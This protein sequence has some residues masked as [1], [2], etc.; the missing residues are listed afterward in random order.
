MFSQWLWDFVFL[1]KK[2]DDYNKN[3]DLTFLLHVDILNVDI[4]LH[5][6]ILFSQFL[7]DINFCFNV[8]WLQSMETYNINHQASWEEQWKFKV[9]ALILLTAD[10]MLSL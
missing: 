1:P 4:C 6:K 5:E 7:W 8:V 9:L 10:L 3:Q 2:I